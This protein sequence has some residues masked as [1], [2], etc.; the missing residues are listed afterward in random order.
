[1]FKGGL[2]KT[3]YLSKLY[4]GIARLGGADFFDAGTVITTDGPDGLHLTA[5]AEKK[6]GTAVATKVK[7]IFK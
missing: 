4:E 1:M 6:L 2:Q 5:E 3:K 7:E